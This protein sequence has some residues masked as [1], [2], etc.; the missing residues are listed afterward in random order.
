[1]NEQNPNDERVIAE[2]EAIIN[3]VAE[4]S[5]KELKAEQ[6]N[7]FVTIE[8][9]MFETFGFDDE[10]AMLFHM[11]MVAQNPDE[12]AQVKRKYGHDRILNDEG[13]E[14]VK[15]MAVQL[16]EHSGDLYGLLHNKKDALKFASSDRSVGC[17]VRVGAYKSEN[18]KD[19]NVAPSEAP[20]REDAIIVVMIT[21]DVIQTI[22]RTS[23]GNTV[24]SQQ[25]TK[26]YEIG[27]SKLI[28]GLF[29]YYI[30]PQMMKAQ[31]PELFDALMLDYK[32]K[33]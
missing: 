5:D 16:H 26:D 24:T 25:I 13:E 20:D 31:A 10:E 22:C 8:A 3:N 29:H 21:N 28:D 2:A 4:E 12:V 30:F 1:M 6:L 23:D 14:V 33:E 19:L 18:A 27:D 11:V 9:K 17:I 7:A 32:D 15:A